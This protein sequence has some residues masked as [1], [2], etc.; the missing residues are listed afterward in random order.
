MCDFSAIGLNGVGTIHGYYTWANMFRV[1]NVP[2]P[3]N[4]RFL[5]EILVMPAEKTHLP[6][7]GTR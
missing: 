1:R 7:I 2:N 5:P 4:V 6:S 3:R